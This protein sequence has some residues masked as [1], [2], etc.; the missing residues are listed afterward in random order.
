MSAPSF[1]SLPQGEI[2]DS[3]D[4]NVALDV[5]PP[6]AVTENVSSVPCRVAPRAA[7]AQGRRMRRRP[8]PAAQ[9]PHARASG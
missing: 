7:A 5:P 4:T 8:L 2:T 9:H 3:D 6:H 1:S